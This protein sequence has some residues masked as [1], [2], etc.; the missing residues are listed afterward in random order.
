MRPQNFQLP[1]I[2][3]IIVLARLQVSSC[4]HLDRHA[5]TEES[6]QRLRAK[7]YS[8]FLKYFGTI[9]KYHRAEDKGYDPVFAVSRRLVPAGP[10]ALHN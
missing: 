1:L 6:E 4:R 3:I 2:V 5:R 9:P 8:A 10:N 7:F